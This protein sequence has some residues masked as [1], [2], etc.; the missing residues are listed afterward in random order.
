MIYDASSTLESTL[1]NKRLDIA[2]GNQIHKEP[3]HTIDH[4]NSR[5]KLGE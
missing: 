1:S 5:I 4:M 3:G 2:L